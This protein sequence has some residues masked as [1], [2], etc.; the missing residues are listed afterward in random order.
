L[1]GQYS[2]RARF[3]RLG[4]GRNRTWEVSMTDPVKFVILGA[5]VD[6]VAGLS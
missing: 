2:S 1:P 5:L 3:H 4:Q 6:A